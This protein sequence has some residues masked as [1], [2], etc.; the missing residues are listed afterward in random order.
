MASGLITWWRIDGEKVEAVTDFIFLG[1][2]ITLGGDCS[3][4]IKILAPWKESYDKAR[5]LIKKQRHHFANKGLY[6]WSYDI[7]SSHEWMWELD[8]KE[9]WISKNWYLWVMVL[10][11]TQ[12]S[13]GQKVD[14]TS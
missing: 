14:Q 12:E 4:E 8:H 2:K 11:K 10:Q 3:H 13:L 6:S 5:Q 9:G 7:S 1:S